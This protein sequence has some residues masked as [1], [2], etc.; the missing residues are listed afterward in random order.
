[1]VSA[2]TSTMI[3]SGR[4]PA[5]ALVERADLLDLTVSEM[6]VVVGG[7]RALDANAGGSKHGVLTKR[8]GTLTNDFFVNLLDLSTEWTPSGDHLEGRDRASGDVKWTATEVD[9]VFGS[10]AELRAVAELYATSRRQPT[11]RRRLR[12]RLDQG[13]DPRSIRTRTSLTIDA[14]TAAAMQVD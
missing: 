1:M 9:L 4:S 14:A 2:T 6:T 3:S 13:H 8:P 5:V 10:N 7:L 12:E 11:L